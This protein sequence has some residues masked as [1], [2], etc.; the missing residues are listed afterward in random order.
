MIRHIV[1]CTR[2]AN[3]GLYLY[4]RER[5]RRI[6]S[7]YVRCP[8]SNNNI[9]NFIASTFHRF[10][11]NKKAVETKWGAFFANWWW[12]SRQIWRIARRSI[13][14]G[15]IIARASKVWTTSSQ[16]AW[17][18]IYSCCISIFCRRCKLS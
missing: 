11:A 8:V 1:Y 15:T 5:P 7:L 9:V 6:R 14:N 17:W 2:S 12:R 4:I 13:Q 3:S 10:P 16:N 18:T